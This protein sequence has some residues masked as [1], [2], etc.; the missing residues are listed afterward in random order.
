MVRLTRLFEPGRIG[1]LEIRNRIVMAPIS[2]FSCQNGLVTD[3]M[4]D[5]YAERARGGVG[6]IITRLAN[7]DR[8]APL[9]KTSA[10]FWDD[11]SISR[12]TDLT[13]EVHRYGAMVA[14]QL[15]F[16]GTIGYSSETID[17]VGPSAVP[18]LPGGVVPRE[19]SVEDIRRLVEAWSEAARR[20]RDAGFDAIEIQGCHGGL[21][22][23]FASPFYNKR[24]DEYG[25]SPERRIR[26]AC[27]IIIRTREMVGNDFPIIYRIS[28]DDGYIGGTNKDE[29][30]R[31]A[32]LVEK[33]GADAIHVSS[34]DQA[35][36]VIV[37]TY[38]TPPGQFVHLAEGIKRLVKVPVIAV[39]SLGDPILA[40][41]VLVEE[42]ADFVAMGRPLLADPH[43]PN[44]AR[45]GRM[46]DINYCLRCN[47]C[48]YRLTN[49]PME[50]KPV[51]RPLSCTIN[52]ALFRESEFVI[53]PARKRKIVMVVGGGLAGM[54]AAAILAE[55][56]HHVTLYE[57]GDRLG[58]QWNVA[59]C[60]KAKA[61]YS[62][63]LKALSGEL[64]QSGAKVEMG[65]PVDRET[66]RQL[67]PDVVVVATG[68]TPAVLDVPGV[69]GRHVIQANDVIS[70]RAKVGERVAVIG[71]RYRGM[72]V[73]VTLAE[74]GKQVHLVT[75]R[76]LG[77]DTEQFL[78]R[79]LRDRLIDLGVCIYPYSQVIEITDTGVS[80]F[81]EKEFLSLKADTVVLA[82]G[83]RSVNSLAEEIRSIV[84]EVY[85]VGDCIEPR[86]ALDAINEGADVGLKI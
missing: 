82:I 26:F 80:I 69:N 55:R 50:G 74:Q 53:K 4:I 43:L 1:K 52:P 16:D 42:K 73:A 65:S 15:G 22:N 33:A 10:A 28:G 36:S 79:N 30:Q 25:G 47:N 78:Y 48:V 64:E 56:G 49:S 6:L 11:S 83:S 29:A 24:A 60:E 51:T 38:L 13:D 37:P 3:A 57:T 63:L 72:D 14:V 46:G 8:L 68:A 20:A 27:E 31:Q 41:R 9:G 2:T 66:V 17:V 62:S 70:G 71:G 40:E 18:H 45:D 5:F 77:R 84:P 35:N 75:R 32:Q 34:G 7:V 12:L 86:S 19:L 23:K 59:C 81:R 67:R 58:G 61:G 21:V 85:M 39:G 76:K 44:K 54:K